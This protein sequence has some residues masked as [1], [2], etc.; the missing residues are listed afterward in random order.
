VIAIVIG[1]RAGLSADVQ[2]QLQE[3]GTYHVIAISGGNIAILA[4]LL[5][6]AFRIAG[7][8][9]RGAMVCAIALIA[10]YAQLVGGGSSVD[11]ATLMAV[12][13]FGARAI[14]QRSPPLNSLAVVAALLVAS[15]PLT[16][17]DPAFLLTFG[18]TL[19]ILIVVPVFGV[20]RLPRGLEWMWTMLVASAAA[21]VLLMPIGALS[22]SR[23][24][25]AGLAL[26]ALAI[27]LMGLAQVAGMAVVGAAVIAPPLAS[28]I[29][30][31]AHAGADGLVRSASFVRLAPALEWRVAPPKLWLCAIYYVS[32]AWSWA[33]WR[34]RVQISGSAEAAVARRVRVASA[35]VAVLAGCWIALDPSTLM[36]A[37]GDGTLH[38]TV[39]DVG[40]GDAIFVVFPHGSTLLV[41]AGGLGFAST[42]DIGDRVVAP[43]IRALGFR[44][45]DR[46]ALTHGDP[47]HIG[48]AAS[49]VREFRPREVW[50]GVPVPRS[51]ALTRLRVE[52][53]SQGARW[54]NIFAGDHITI[55]DVTVTVHHPERPDWERQKI[56]N[57]DSLVV[58][59]RWREVSIVLTG[60]VGR[61]PEQQ[62]V[63]RIEPA[64]LRIVKIPHHGSLTSSTPRFVDALHPTIAIASAGRSNHFGHP[65]PEVLERY[66]AIG[67]RV[68]RTDRDGAVTI[69]TDGETVNVD[70][71]V[72]KQRAQR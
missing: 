13:H 34:H 11:R 9:G 6:G 64:R 72:G 32:L 37:R 29:G 67:A 17:V 48:G 21:E 15:N 54:S 60:D 26:N 12:V 38:V 57:D 47:D 28:A 61:V 45:I 46:L 49:V 69:E 2:R 44:R 35:L 70:T 18:A 20:Q 10:A 16:A 1:D 52:T 39:L 51:D 43:A 63:S 24:T 3:A 25:L 4:G 62:L 68:F 19:A 40:Q 56:R 65:V 66:R 5:L 55:D 53:Q 8:F 23:V 42:F 58:E 14:D 59:L 22:F 7:W 41:D 36:A 50:E 27:P 30:W 31:M 33:A 71:F